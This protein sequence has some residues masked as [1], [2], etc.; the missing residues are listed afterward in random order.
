MSVWKALQL[1]V[2]V[3]ACACTSTG[4][5]PDTDGSD[6]HLPTDDTDRVV[7]SG[8]ELGP[9]PTLTVGKGELLFEES[10][11]D[12]G[13]SVLIHGLQGGFH[14]FISIRAS[15]LSL[16]GPWQLRVVG[17]L[18]GEVRAVAPLEREPECNEAVDQGESLGTW[19][20]WRGQPED[21]HDRQA[22]IEVT[23]EDVDGRVVEGVGTQRIWDPLLAQ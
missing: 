13:R 17:S 2:V 19:L 10:D 8:C 5:D 23:V 15:H 21:L 22:Q 9:D 20:I 6:T 1:G 12:D 18:D 16:D 4:D 3:V 11:A 7:V 14:T